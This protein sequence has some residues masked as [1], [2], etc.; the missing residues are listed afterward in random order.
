MNK[1]RIFLLIVTLFLFLPVFQV[2]AIYVA[3]D[4][5]SYG[6][7]SNGAKC[8]GKNCLVG[9]RGVR[10]KVVD[11][12]G[13]QVYN[14]RVVNL[15]FDYNDS[16]RTWFKKQSYGYN[17]VTFNSGECSKLD[18]VNGTCDL[19]KG[20]PGG[21]NNDLLNDSITFTPEFISGGT[22]FHGAYG[23]FSAFAKDFNLGNLF[24]NYTSGAIND[25]CKNPSS[26]NQFLNYAS[27]I[28]GNYFSQGNWC[29]LSS[30]Q[31]NNNFI[32][33]EPTAVIKYNGEYYWGTAYELSQLPYANYEDLNYLFSRQTSCASI[34]TG[35]LYRNK[36]EKNYP[37][38]GLLSGS[39][40]NGNLKYYDTNYCDDTSY[41]FSVDEVQGNNGIAIKVLWLGDPDKTDCSVVENSYKQTSGK[42]L[43]SMNYMEIAGLG[44]TLLYTN[45][46]G[47]KFTADWYLDACTC[48]G[49]NK[50]YQEKYGADLKTI[51]PLENLRNIFE[52]QGIF[53]DYERWVKDNKGHEAARVWNYNKYVK[54]CRTDGGGDNPD[55]P[56][57]P[58]CTPQFGGISSGNPGSCYT[59]QISYKD[60]NEWDDCV[61]NDNGHY[62]I[63]NHKVSNTT[64]ANTYYDSSIGNA[65]YCKV[66]CTEELETSFAPYFPIVSAGQNFIWQ[67]H[68]VSGSRTCKTKTIEYDKFVSDLNRA[69]QDTINKYVR[70]KLEEKLAAVTWTESATNDCNWSC[71]SYYPT[72][73]CC[74]KEGKNCGT[75]GGGC[76]S[77]S[78][79]S[80]NW[81]PSSTY[82]SFSATSS[83]YS[84]SASKSLSTT[85]GGPGYTANVSSYESQYKSALNY[86]NSLVQNMKSCYNEGTNQNWT[87]NLYKVDPKASMTYSGD[88]KYSY[89]GDLISSTNYT[90]IS[91]TLD[92]TADTQPLITGC[93][94]S[95]CTIT[96]QAM[97]KCKTVEMTKGASTGFYLD[98]GVYRYVNKLT[99]ESFHASE[100]GSND[101]KN[102]IDI[103]Q[104]NFP[105]SYATKPGDYDGLILNYSNLGHIKNG[106][107]VVDSIISDLQNNTGTN[108][109]V[110]QCG[111]TVTKGVIPDPNNPNKDGGIIVIYRPIDLYD[112]FPSIDADGRSTGWNWGDRYGSTSNTNETVKQVILN[113]RNV[114]GDEVYN[115]TPMYSFTLTPSLIKSIREY[116]RTTVYDDENLK[117]DKNTGER[118][119]SDYLTELIQLTGATGACTQDRKGTFDTCR[120]QK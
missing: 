62:T 1:K 70:Y 109:G 29:G 76:A 108:Y 94:G 107:S 100:L 22:N 86:A 28:F 72:Y 116:N 90:S 99:G 38:P 6:G 53:K 36:I 34:L 66:Y 89:S 43:T 14:T 16:T 98:E 75:C 23:A 9:Y 8:S 65:S 88:S 12:Y 24:K 54:E 74:D 63:D 110:Y 96:N 25:Q 27:Q 48:E 50:F 67:G 85:C 58:D 2:E 33:M 105:V 46:E 15:Q 106:R 60:T 32:I 26:D 18:Y 115:L 119:I 87:D 31:K 79:K 56:K 95:N 111:Y 73:K 17:F 51:T 114:K 77:G 41:R 40:F 78:Y 118:C 113:N 81:T 11:Q 47:E 103:G 57:G 37:I 69:N 104:G 61:F 13:N 80:K 42:D 39:Y 5:T 92:C 83:K 3:Q 35:D 84:G 10:I 4:G 52:N 49:L 91:K 21:I 45:P 102:Y 120:Y 117:C 59:G 93:S 112:P 30:E 71:D 101:Q 68:S 20:A 82:E 19:D 44:N 55:D 64:S 97:Q 7:L